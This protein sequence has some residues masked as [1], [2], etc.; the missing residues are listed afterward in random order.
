MQTRTFTEPQS[1]GEKGQQHAMVA[2]TSA[3]ALFSGFDAAGGKETIVHHFTGNPDGKNPVSPLIKD[4]A[5]NLFGTTLWGG[6]DD[7]VVFKVNQA[8]KETVLYTF[9]SQP[10]CTDGANPYA[11][12]L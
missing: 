10:Y 11:G 2:R 4:S 1:K 6:V 7:G 9:C 8:G 12:V 5:G 3:A